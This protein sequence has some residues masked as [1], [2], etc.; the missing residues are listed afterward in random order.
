MTFKPKTTADRL[1]AARDILEAY[2]DA[3]EELRVKDSIIVGFQIG[4]GNDGQPCK[5]QGIN[6]VRNITFP[7]KE[8]A[9]DNDT[10]L[11]ETN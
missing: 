4:N 5:L 2:V 10:Q 11:V 6:A 8:I 1:T 9:Q 7:S 3:I